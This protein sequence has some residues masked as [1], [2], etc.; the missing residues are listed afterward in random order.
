MRCGSGSVYRWPC[1]LLVVGTDKTVLLL[2]M[3]AHTVAGHAMVVTYP[4]VY[5]K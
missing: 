1:R 3:D 4:F 5:M 2:V